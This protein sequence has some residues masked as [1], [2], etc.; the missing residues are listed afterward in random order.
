LTLYKASVTIAIMLKIRLQRFGKKNQPT[1]RVVLV[2]SQRGPQSGNFKEIL[3]SLPHGSEMV[4][5]TERILHWIAL[6]AQPSD[7]VH[8]LLIKEG[9]I[10]GAKRDVSSKKNVG[11][12]KTREA[13]SS[14]QQ[15]ADLG[16]EVVKPTGEIPPS[17]EPTGEI[18]QGGEKEEALTE[19]VKEVE[20]TAE[21]P[22]GGEPALVESAP[23]PEEPKEGEGEK[24][25]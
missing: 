7:R 12:T 8:N 23:E 20:A 13:G 19:D 4:L 6:G 18:S 11:K 9:A 2:D 1:F 15:Q 10:T 5:N 3:G 25:V 14:D 17:G 22:Q 16:N 24:K 21:I